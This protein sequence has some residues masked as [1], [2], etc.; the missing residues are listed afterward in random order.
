MEIAADDAGITFDGLYLECKTE[1]FKLLKEL[2][3]GN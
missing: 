1:I 3:G 2:A